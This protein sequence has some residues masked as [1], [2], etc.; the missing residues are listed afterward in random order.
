MIYLDSAATSLPKPKAVIEAMS[1]ACRRYG[2]PGRSGH[3]ASLEAG[4]A[5]YNCRAALG[6]FLGVN[7]P[8]RIVF[9]SNCTDA[10]NQ[11]IKGMLHEG[12]HVVTTA[13]EHNSVL[14]PLYTLKERLLITLSVVYPRSDGY[15][16]PNDIAAEINP[17]TRLVVVTHASNVTGAV[18]RIGDIAAICTQRNVPLL[19]DSA[20]AIGCIPVNIQALGADMVAFPG[21][22]GLLGPQ[23]CG[24]LYIG[25]GCSPLPLREGGTGSSSL[26]LTQPMDLPD[27][28]ESGTA[29]TPAIAG[30]WAGVTYVQKNLKSIMD[31]EERLTAQLWDGLK[32]I[33]G[34]TLYGPPPGKPRV[35]VV[36][37]N[38]AN[39]AA[40]EAA[41]RLSVEN[42]IACRAG[43]HCAPLAHRF[44]G[45]QEIGAIRFSIGPFN[46]SADI[47]LAV[48]AVGKLSARG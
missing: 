36:T 38:I 22:K 16:E 32:G 47:H 18:Q 44:L 21:H 33:K 14:R 34:V 37:F 1:T 10:L 3:K 5:I 25:A 48:K 6:Q 26:S 27:R 7:D 46:S 13:L 42:D 9:C 23:G 4:Q 12:G 43:L 41:D 29:A 20:Q 30:L 17:R 15:I 45:T 24:G 19:V 11:A 39:L 35:G 2:N 28:Y 40:T 31:I 8:F